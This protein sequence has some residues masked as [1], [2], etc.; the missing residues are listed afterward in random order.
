MAI[1]FYTGMPAHTPYLLLH[2]GLLVPIFS[3][4]TLGLAGPHIISTLFSIRPLVLL[5]EASFALYLLHFN[6]YLLLHNY[7]VP[8]RLH[9]AAFDP[10]LSYALLLVIAYAAFRLVETPSRNAIMKRFSRKHHHPQ[11]T[12]A[13]APAPKPAYF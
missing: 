8:E 1:F 12:P 6:V 5:G 9:L 4:I 2:G 10:W 3:I 7:H 13:P 11:P